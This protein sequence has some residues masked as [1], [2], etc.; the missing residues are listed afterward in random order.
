M[1][2][3]LDDLEARH[4]DC[5]SDCWTRVLLGL[6]KQLHHWGK[7]EGAEGEGAMWGKREGAEGEG[8]M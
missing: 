1:N 7:R 2:E 5:C 6:T 4:G 3:P 8:E